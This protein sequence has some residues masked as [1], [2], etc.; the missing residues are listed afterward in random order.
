MVNQSDSPFKARKG[1]RYLYCFGLG[2]GVIHRNVQGLLLI[3]R[4]GITPGKAQGPKWV[5]ENELKFCFLL[6]SRNLLRTFH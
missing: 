2:L 3:L 5:L 6:I 4:S 1:S